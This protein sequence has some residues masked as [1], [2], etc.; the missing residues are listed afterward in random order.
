MPRALPER[1]PVRMQEPTRSELPKDSR[2]QSS[3]VRNP[4]AETEPKVQRPS[5]SDRSLSRAPKAKELPAFKGKKQSIDRTVDARTEPK[6]ANNSSSSKRIEIDFENDGSS[7]PTTV[8]VRK[9]IDFNEALESSSNEAE[10]IRVRSRAVISAPP[11]DLSDLPATQ[12]EATLQA[13]VS[14]GPA[15][16]SLTTKEPA[17]TSA[18]TS[19]ASTSSASSSKGFLQATEASP[20]AA[21][22]I[23]EDASSLSQTKS[24]LPDAP[25]STRLSTEAALEEAEFRSQH[26][27][28][29]REALRR[30]WR[31]PE[32]EATLAPQLDSEKTS[33]ADAKIESP[34]G[35]TTAPSLEESTSSTQISSTQ[36]PA[37]GPVTETATTAKATESAQIRAQTPVTGPRGQW[38]LGDR[39]SVSVRGGALRAQWSQFD[40]RMRNGATSFGLGLAQELMSPWGS[41]EARASFD[42]YHAI[43]QAVTIDNLRMIS[44]R[45]EVA[46]WLTHSRV[47]PAL[48]LG[49]GLTEYA[50]RS[51]RA[52]GENGDVTL[53][54]HARGTAFTIIPG[55]ALRVDL[56]Q[57][58]RFDLQTEYLLH[59]GGDQ[60]SRSQGLQVIGALGW[61]L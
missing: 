31:R 6:S 34:V 50:V 21:Q 9:P 28:R 13:E 46:Y 22:V 2:S 27:N 39:R 10:Q 8:I 60:S 54:T 35:L 5:S 44:T 59:L 30:S 14:G 19:S 24:T 52:V 29:L 40:A 17:V 53:R 49:M 48:T 15:K 12:A 55:T 57:D 61:T 33:T 36:K 42:L 7:V 18:S 20:A 4:R 3:E 16:G 32:P 41:L 11:G 43:D 47:R 26:G 23:G 38:A 58:F 37:S 1:Q 45:T 51:Y 25:P 56:N